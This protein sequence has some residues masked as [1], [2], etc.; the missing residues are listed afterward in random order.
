MAC[1]R[2][3]YFFGGNTTFRWTV[4]L[5]YSSCMCLWFGSTNF[6]LYRLFRRRARLSVLHCQ[7]ALSP[8]SPL[9]R[10]M[11]C[12][13]RLLLFVYCFIRSGM[14]PSFNVSGSSHLVCDFSWVTHRG[15]VVSA[16]KERQTMIL[17]SSTSMVF[18]RLPWT[19]VDVSVDP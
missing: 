15:I 16:P 3:F 1:I 17:L 19:F 10:G 12:L 11:F 6:S 2:P 7:G 5:R 18:T 13:R 8:A 4:L 14:G 9:Y